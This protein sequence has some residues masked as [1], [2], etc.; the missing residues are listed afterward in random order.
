MSTL[1]ASLLALLPS[2]VVLVPLALRDPKRLR[3]LPDSP[4]APLPPGTRRLL[5]A[6]LP[7]PGLALGLA[8]Q[9][10]A[11]LIWLGA[12]CSFGWALTQWLAPGS[13]A[14]PDPEFD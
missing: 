13:A 8:G 7:L 14:P 9:W 11:L 6:L 1:A 2:A 10:P 12:S 3:N 4:R 5:G